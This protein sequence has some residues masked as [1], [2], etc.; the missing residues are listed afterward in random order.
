MRK[1]FD[2]HAHDYNSQKGKTCSQ[3]VSELPRKKRTGQASERIN[4][5]ITR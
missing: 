2:T 1:T 4:Q 3:L 5:I